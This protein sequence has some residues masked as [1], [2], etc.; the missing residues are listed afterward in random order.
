MCLM[1]SQTVTKTQQIRSTNQANKARKMV[2]ELDPTYINKLEELAQE[3][4]TSDELRQYLSEEEE[5]LYNQMKDLYEPRISLLYDEVAAKK[6]LQLIH[7]ETLLLHEA[8]EGLFL[9]KILGYSV[10]R[11]L[12]NEYGKYVLP[13]D[14]FMDIL[15]TICQSANF[16]LLKQRI[17]QSI[18]VGF[19]LSS[20]IWITN[21]IN[22]VQNKRIRSYLKSHKLDKYRFEKERKIGKAMFARQFKSDNFLTAEFP[23]DES[24]LKV[25]F[26]QLK[27]FLMYRVSG[28]FDNSSLVPFIRTFV[29][30]E[31]FQGTREHLEMMLIFGMYFELEGEILSELHTIFNTIRKATDDFD[32]DVFEVLLGLHQSSDVEV[33]PEHDLRFSTIV[34]REVEDK[35]SE[36]YDL[37][38]TIHSEGYETPEVQEAVRVYDS[39]HEGK[40]VETECVRQTIAGYFKRTMK[41]YMLADYPKYFDL[42]KLFVVYMDLFDNEQFN[43][44]LKDISMAYVKRLIRKYTDRR[45]KDYQDIKKFVKATFEDFGFMNEKEIKEFFKTRKKRVTPAKR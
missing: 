3:I 1:W 9:P 43:K 34:D 30:H 31:D 32:E 24:E 27:Y 40:A 10:L 44:G 17:G 45:G 23:E 37:M 19:A 15:L 25:M 22:E 7:F 12:L 18:Q 36:Y 42:T 21:L 20:D 4:Q 13:Q 11:G 2:Q 16:D 29:N 26:P 5:E 6:P 14:H 28:D 41:S 35:L 33:K 39:I 8:F 38:V